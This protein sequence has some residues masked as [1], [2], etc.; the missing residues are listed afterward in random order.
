MFDLV[1]SAVVGVTLG[2]Y[3]DAQRKGRVETLVA[4]VRAQLD[5]PTS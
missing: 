2:L 3:A 4:V 5:T 1:I